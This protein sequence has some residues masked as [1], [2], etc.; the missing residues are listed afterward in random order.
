MTNPFV[1]QTGLHAG[2]RVPVGNESL[3]QDPYD[4]SLVLGGPLYQLVRRAHLSG[5]AL[6][7]SSPRIVPISLFAGLPLLI[8][9]ASEKCLRGRRGTP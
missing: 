8:L 4:F 1:R 2:T 6:E 3:P 9:S 5:D 7:L